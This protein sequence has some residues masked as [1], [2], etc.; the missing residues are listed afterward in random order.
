MK[1][2]NWKHWG[3]IL[4]AAAL[5]AFVSAYNQSG[6]LFTAPALEHD[7]VAALFAVLGVFLTKPGDK[8]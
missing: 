6:Q 7:A 4:G 5:S 1:G 2:M 3:V 8:S